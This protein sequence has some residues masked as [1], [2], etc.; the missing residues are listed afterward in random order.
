MRTPAY[1]GRQMREHDTFRISVVSRKTGLSI[2]RIRIWERRYRLV[3][4]ARDAGGVRQYT[5]ADVERLTLA[6]DATAL[7][8]PISRVAALSEHDLRRLL[9]EAAASAAEGA[10]AGGDDPKHVVIASV[11]AAI[12]RYDPSDAERHLNRA[13]LLMTPE[14]LVIDVL[15]PLMHQV[16]TL[17]ES[18]RFG[19]SHEHLVSQLVRNL[20][21][22]LMRFKPPPT[23]GSMLF[24]T[25]PGDPHEFGIVLAAN[26]AAMRGIETYVLGADVPLAD[27][28]STARKI[29][30]RAVIVAST[31]EPG[32][33]TLRGYVDAL[34]K[35]LP[36]EVDLLLAGKGALA[37]SGAYRSAR[38]R[39]VP[40]LR[41]FADLLPEYASARDA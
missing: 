33:A 17:W 5:A 16:G 38:V 10:P 11:L 23:G 41:S 26:L 13:A 25:P 6:R 14:E 4:P 27:V 31:M 7:G 32:G 1:A 36:R 19:I 15:A 34:G 30:P 40:S 20:V 18:E 35:E 28:L 37:L 24:A 3:Q 2:D 9:Q 12:E 21:G 39:F 8:H 22:G 29:V